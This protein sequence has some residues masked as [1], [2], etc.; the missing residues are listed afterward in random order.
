MSP[1]S[2]SDGNSI[3][4]GA[5]G[6]F[7][8]SK[9]WIN[10]SYYGTK[11]TYFADATGDGKADAIVVN[12][13][14]ITV[15]RSDGGTFTENERWSNSSFYGERETYFADVTGDGK[16]DAIVLNDYSIMVRCSDGSKFTD[17]EKWSYSSFLG[18]L[19][20]RYTDGT[21]P[22]G[23]C[24]ADVT[25]DGKADAI[26]VIGTSVDVKTSM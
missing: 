16:A 8:P 15:R 4:R 7:L 22:W 2:S 6:E 9:A 23:N 13:Y 12:D 14:S 19:D 17:N 20:R 26:R 21:T 3:T 10:R 25:G 11:G 18:G 5:N 1:T 24:F